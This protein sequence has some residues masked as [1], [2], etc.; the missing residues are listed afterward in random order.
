M[1]L[2]TLL[3]TVALVSLSLPAQA[4]S[5]GARIGGGTVLAWDDIQRAGNAFGLAFTVDHGPFQG[6]AAFGTVLPDSRVDGR[7]DAWWLE[8]QWHPFRPSEDRRCGAG[9]QL[10]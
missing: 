8:G 9:G 7:F 4:L 2:K 10:G 5:L 3:L 1:K 6:A